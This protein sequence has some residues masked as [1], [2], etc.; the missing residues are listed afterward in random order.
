VISKYVN[1]CL[2]SLVQL[3]I[4][5]KYLIVV[6]AILASALSTWL[7]VQYAQ[8]DTNTENMLSDQLDWRIAHKNYKA[9]FPFFSDTIVI[10]VEGPTA[11]LAFEASS[12]FVKE[13]IK[14]GVESEHIFFPESED[15]F[16]KNKFLYLDSEKL[17]E[18]TDTLSQSQAMLGMLAQ[19]PGV[20]GLL[21]LTN[22]ILD[23]N[24]DQNIESSSSF[25]TS[26]TKSL[27]SFLSG[28]K[29]PM[30]WQNLLSSEHE[31]SEVHRILFT[32][33]PDLK[34]DEL[35]P[36]SKLIDHIRG[37]SDSIPTDKWPNVNVRLTGPAALGYD[38]LNS[39]IEGAG[40]AGIL[41]L[42]AILLVLS[43]GLRSPAAVFSIIFVVFLG[44]TYTSAFATIAIGSF[45]MISIAFSVLYVGLAADFAIHFYSTY[46]EES[47]KNSQVK[48]LER[49]TEHNIAPLSLCAF[50]TSIGFL[51]FMPTAYKGVAE[52]GLIAGVGMIVG[53]LSSFT[54]LPALISIFSGTPLGKYQKNNYKK[55]KSL[56][57][58]SRKLF[59]IA[60]VLIFLGG[61]NIAKQATFDANPIH[62]N[63]PEAES[64]LTLHDL[65]SD[66]L[67]T[68][69]TI[70]FIAPN[71]R[72]AQ[73]LV[74][75]LMKLPGV[76]EVKTLQDFI[77]DDQDK[78][79]Q[80][81]QNMM[82]SL[83]GDIEISSPNNDAFL[84]EKNINRN[85]ET[86]KD[87][88]N[89]TF[90]IVAFSKTLNRL[91]QANMD[92]DD[93]GKKR[94]YRQLDSHIMRHFPAL[95]SQI[96]AGT[97][98]EKINLQSL[99]KALKERWVS[100]DGSYRLEI[101]P[102]NV[103][104]TN[105]EM[106]QFIKK[107]REVVGQNATGIPIINAEASQ[108][109]IKSFMQ[110]FLFAIVVVTSVVWLS[111]R[112]VKQLLVVMTPL[113]VGCVCTVAVLVVLEMSF[114]FA[115]IIALPL[116]IG[117]S[118]DSTLHV[119]YRYKRMQQKDEHFLRTSTAKAVFLSALTTGASFGNLAF[120]P[121]A[122]TASMGVLLSI[123]LVVNLICSLI[124]L[125]ILLEYFMRP[126]TTNHEE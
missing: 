25:V 104:D 91:K 113:V 12:Y 101:I 36:G 42:I 105:E 8:I 23:E 83:G 108:A 93:N 124:L 29:S 14:F 114:N 18:V 118:V 126:R 38:E 47:I 62:L 1:Q 20:L 65:S 78:K 98:A 115:N 79:L 117:I 33:Q 122:G 57:T 125:P 120:S 50:T 64:V 97:E 17:Q 84:L 95:I 106:G 61:L 51:A 99:P 77:P 56:I 44:L 71:E 35:L 96:N 81:I 121:H 82:W 49:A 87:I 43:I 13:I 103:L 24:I 41:A 55:N 48:A 94:F 85:I 11:E 123:G 19:D 15:F 66:G 32:I 53:L 34:F 28:A 9:K 69:D 72:K 39:V 70:N 73:S 92:L 76:K 6:T 59:F 74:G 4:R 2:A 26:L 68:I 10:V 5:K 30:S 31:I 100:N 45:N 90:Q 86:I 109:V 58:P 60:S 80:I 54:I 89:P 107:V 116:L 46:L 119:L 111:T 3:S 37:I 112:N 16:R 67:V 102:T 52:L 40:Q 21:D 110:A 27:N 88:D 63:N 7:T 75:A 22:L